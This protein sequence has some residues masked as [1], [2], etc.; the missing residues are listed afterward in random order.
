[1]ELYE[2]NFMNKYYYYTS[3]AEPVDFNG[4]HYTPVPIERNEINLDI[5]M[6]GAIITAPIDTKPFA[7]MVTNPSVSLPEIK[8]IK[9]PAGFVF[10][11]GV[12][13][14]CD[15]DYTKRQ[16][17]VSIGSKYNLKEVTVPK[18]SYSKLCSFNFCDENCGLNQEDFKILLDNGTFSVEGFNIQSNLLKN[19]EYDLV[20][21]YIV[22]SKNETQ[23]IVDY[24]K[25]NGII[26]LLKPLLFT[27]INN[28]TVYYGCSKTTDSCEKYNNLDNFGGFPFIPQKNI[29]TSGF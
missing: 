7:Y 3:G 15:F 4:K 24:D 6:N 2:L 26:T 11:K 25:T 13:I 12:V 8:I 21:G 20:S 19:R 22:T 14:S 16:V 18:R 1:M 17:K 27:D 23:Y 28:I 29:S 5:D 10:F 9:Y